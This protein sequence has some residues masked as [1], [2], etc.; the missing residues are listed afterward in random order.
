MRTP[1][2]R[3]TNRQTLWLVIVAAVWCVLWVYFQRWEARRTIMY[4]QRDI[5]RSIMLEAKQDI[6]AAGH[7]ASEIRIERPLGTYT[8][9]WT[10]W[11]EVWENRD[12]QK[13][14]LIRATVSGDNGRFSLQP[15]IVETYGSKLDAAWLDRLLRTYRA[16]GWRYKVIQAAGSEYSRK[17]QEWIRNE[18]TGVRSERA[19]REP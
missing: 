19:P 13:L 17:H 9:E 6:V 3:L 8:A 5:T 2:F 4:Q 15:I 16:K 10:E 12:G 11:L 18:K 7:T 14:S 1:E